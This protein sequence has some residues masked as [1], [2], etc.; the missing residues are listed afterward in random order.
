M[1]CISLI[2]FNIYFCLLESNSDNTSSSKSTGYSPISS[3]IISKD[4]NLIVK[5]AVRCCPCEP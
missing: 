4:A 3:F 2:E 1:V 5:V